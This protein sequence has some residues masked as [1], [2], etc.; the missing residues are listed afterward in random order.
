APLQQRARDEFRERR[1]AIEH[2]K[3]RARRRVRG[4]AAIPIPREPR[5]RRELG[6]EDVPGTSHP[7][8]ATPVVTGALDGLVNDRTGDLGTTQSEV[9]VAAHGL[10]VLAAWN[11]GATAEPPGPMGFGF[12]RDGGHTWR[13]GGVFPLGGGV[14]L[15]ESDPTIAVDA[16]GTFFVGGLV[17]SS[18]PSRNALAVVS[19]AF[20]DTGFVWGVPTVV[21]AVRDTLPDKLWLTIDPASGVLHLAYTTFV[22]TRTSI[23]DWID[24]QSSRDGNRTWDPPVKLSD[25]AEDGL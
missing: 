7:P 22:L 4:H 23:T 6:L 18:P 12:S 1:E 5:E 9:S 11:D 17:I 8:L 25:P 15:W 13:D 10:D 14:A 16:A 3:R 20:A 2:L 21:R 24:L 19:G